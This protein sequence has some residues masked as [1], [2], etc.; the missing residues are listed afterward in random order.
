MVSSDG[1]DTESQWAARLG[2]RRRDGAVEI[3]AACADANP[4][5]TAAATADTA[6]DRADTGWCEWAPLS[7]N[8]RNPI[9]DRPISRRLSPPAAAPVRSAALER[10]GAPAPA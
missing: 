4:C 6:T 9:V 3:C 7:G 1:G 5:A 2:V 10:R 8:D